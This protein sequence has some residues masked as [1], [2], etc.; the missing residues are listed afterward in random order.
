MKLI[1]SEI[2]DFIAAMN[3]FANR[4]K[5]LQNSYPGI[6]E[7]VEWCSKYE[8]K[9]SP[10]L[11]NDISLLIE[12]M[13]FPSIYL[14]MIYINTSGIESVDDFLQKLKL[15]NPDELFCNF[16]K[17]FLGGKNDEITLELLQDLFL[18]EGLHPG[19]DPA[20]EAEL[21]FIF[22]QDPENFLQRLYKT[23]YD[24]YELAYKPE[25]INL[26]KLELKKLQWHQ[27]R[28]ND[29]SKKY[30]E[31]LGVNSFIKSLSEDDEP[32]LYFSL[33]SDTSSSSFWG[34]QTLV[35]GAGTDR[36]I[37]NQS[38]RDKS[39]IFFSCF[40]DPKRLE[41]L[42]LT[43]KRPWYSTELAT[44]FKLK[45]ATLSYHINILVNADLLNIVKGEAKRFYYTL[46]KKVIKDYLGFVSQDLLGF[47]NDLKYN[48]D[49][50]EIKND[51]F[52][53]SYLDM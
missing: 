24:F 45:P 22:L 2:V 6:P 9:L 42:R 19:Y 41:I 11:L 35:I 17:D 52:Y 29:D 18:N 47:D 27:N 26:K 53:K 13:T 23:Y 31:Q 10:F 25:R 44:H 14:F 48:S 39:N 37:I 1:N 30:F 8:K 20:E 28:L 51:R 4:N 16:R 32:R 43:A 3:H 46:N 21:L 49:T 36:R 50:L 40:G 15:I 38:A 12:K 34:C 5:Q 33:F 7:L